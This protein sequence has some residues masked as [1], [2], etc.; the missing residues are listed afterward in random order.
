M[1]PLPSQNFH[2]VEVRRRATLPPL[3][4]ATGVFVLPDDTLAA[5]V[6]CIA[7]NAHAAVE[8]LLHKE[9][10]ASAPNVSERERQ[11]RVIRERFAGA[12]PFEK[13]TE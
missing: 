9:G 10:K 7:L 12:K 3:G 6:R 5:A 13:S 1:S 8:L 11:L 4:P 2:R